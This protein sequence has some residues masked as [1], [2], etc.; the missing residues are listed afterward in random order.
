MTPWSSRSFFN[1]LRQV[2]FG[3]AAFAALSLA[4]NQAAAAASLDVNPVLVDIVVPTEPVELRVTNTGTDDLSLQID[5][6]IWTQ[7]ADGTDDLNFTDLLLAVPPLFTVTPGEQQ[8]VRI[9]YLGAPSEDFE[10][11]FRLLLTELAPPAA[12]RD[13]SALNM[14]MQLSIP[15]FVAPLSGVAAP[16]I[17]LDSIEPAT[18]GANLTLRNTGNA[19]AK[20][21]GVDLL[22][23]SGWSQ[24]SELARMA[25]YLLPDS[26]ADVQVPGDAASIRAVRVISADGR[27]WEHAVP[28]AR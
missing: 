25:Q 11:S 27:D 9:G 14:R 16:Q 1:V 18:D 23:R 17:V 20:V 19:H 6:R 15:V 26:R 21:L 13:R 10:M 12:E 28:P 24:P 4:F 2:S 8:I 3:A 22:G 7:T 5:T